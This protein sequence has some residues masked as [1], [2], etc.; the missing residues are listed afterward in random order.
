[1]N[2]FKVVEAK[3]LKKSKSNAAKHFLQAFKLVTNF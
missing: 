2:L 3:L 1:M